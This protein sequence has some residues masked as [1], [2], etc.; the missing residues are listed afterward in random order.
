MMQVLTPQEQKIYRI[1]PYNPRMGLPD[2][3][4]HYFR[5]PLCAE[6]LPANPTSM[7][8]GCGNLYIEQGSIRF[9][10]EKIVPMLLK[11]KTIFDRVFSKK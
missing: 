2:G 6:I 5:C 1:I 4:G 3:L 8:C 7:K 10:D 9:R 11:K